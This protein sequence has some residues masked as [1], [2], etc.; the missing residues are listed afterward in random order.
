MCA[1]VLYSSS[2]LTDRCARV[3]GVRDGMI[4][5]VSIL[6]SSSNWKAQLLIDLFAENGTFPTKLDQ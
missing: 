3:P 2:W 6:Q 1:D 4:S 5:A